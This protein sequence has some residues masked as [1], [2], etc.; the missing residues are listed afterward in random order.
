MTIDFIQRFDQ[1]DVTGR[2]P[3]W[4]TDCYRTYVLFG[5]RIVWMFERFKW[6]TVSED[7]FGDAD[8][9][10]V[11][12]YTN[13]VSQRLY[14]MHFGGGTDWYLGSTLFGALSLS[15]DGECSLYGDVIKLR[16]KYELGDRS[17]AAS[18][19]RNDFQIVPELEGSINLWWYPIEAIQVH[20]GWE[21]MAF[22]NTA[23]AR[24]PIDFNFGAIAPPYSRQLVR[25]Y[26]GF[27]FGV[28]FVF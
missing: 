10:D 23:S 3:I 20:M 13:T 11:A 18:R 28:G 5:P 27:T 26:H 7:I 24:E 25:F 12:N 6:R 4:E 17:T 8:P 9:D 2:V 22:F 1:F 19:P 21:I 16:P 15:V 14:G